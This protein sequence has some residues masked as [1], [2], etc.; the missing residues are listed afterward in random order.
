MKVVMAQFPR[1]IM[2]QQPAPVTLENFAHLNPV[3]YRSLTQPLDADD[4][5]RDIPFELESTN[6]APANYVTIAA[7]HLKVPAVQ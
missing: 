4:W 3:S 6:V 5:L 7:Y 2:N 1:P